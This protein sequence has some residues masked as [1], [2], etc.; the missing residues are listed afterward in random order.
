VTPIDLIGSW[1]LFA[2]EVESD[3]HVTLIDVEHDRFEW[4]PSVDACARVKP[5]IVADGIPRALAVPAEPITF[6]PLRRTDLANMVAWQN[7]PHVQRWW[8]D[9]VSD[10]DA[11]EKKYGPPIDG[12]SAITVDIVVVSRRPVGFIQATPLGADEEP[13]DAAGWATDGVLT[14]LSNTR[15]VVA[16]PVA[17]NIASVRACEKAGFRRMLEFEAQPGQSRHA[18]RLFDRTRVLGDST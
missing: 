5:R 7:A 17:A 18:L 10:D 1:A 2:A 12:L 3:T 13:L 16:D 15:F 4:P 14:R 9:A 11:A 6:C 8:T